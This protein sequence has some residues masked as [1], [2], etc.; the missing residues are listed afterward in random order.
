MGVRLCVS[1]LPLPP[2][3]RLNYVEQH[4]ERLGLDSERLDNARVNASRSTP[5][6]D[7]L[8][9]CSK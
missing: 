2:P 8:D 4:A 7:T 6:T 3:C 5:M 1:L 9:V